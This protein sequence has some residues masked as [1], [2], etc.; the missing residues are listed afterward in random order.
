M[1]VYICEVYMREVRIR[2]LYIRGVRI[3]E[4]RI[5]EVCIHVYLFIESFK[6]Y[7]MFS[8]TK[9]TLLFCLTEF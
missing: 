3:C 4:V 1:Y 7:I 6:V 2:D 8:F 9:N 5:R